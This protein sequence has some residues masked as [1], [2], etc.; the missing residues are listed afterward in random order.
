[1]VVAAAPPRGRLTVAGAALA[2]RREP[3]VQA[4]VLWCVVLFASA[5]Q[6]PSFRAAALKF[7]LRSLA[8]ILAF[9]AARSLARPPPVVR[10][11]VAALIAGALLSAATAL[12][13]VGAPGTA[14]LWSPFREGHFASLGLARASGVFA[15]PTIA[16]M[17]WEAAVPLLVAAPVALRKNVDGD[18]RAAAVAVLA[19]VLPVAAIFAS[20]TRSGLAGTA[21]ACAALLALGW[22]S[23]IGVRRA[24]GGTLAVVVV[25]WSLA[26]LAMPTGSFLGQRL[27][28]WQDENWFRV[29]YLVDTEPRTLHVGEVFTVPVTLHNT[30]AVIWPR[31][32]QQPT[33]LGYHWQRLDGATTL[34]DYEGLRTELPEDVVPGG[35]LEVVAKARGPA[36]EGQY[37]LH[38]DVVQEDV[39]WFSDRGNVMPDQPVTVLPALAGT[40][41]VPASDLEPPKGA[42]PPP[43]RSALWRAAV[44]LW[45]ER[46]VLGIGPDNFRRRYQAVLSPAPTGQPYTDTRLH[47]NSLYFET[48]ADLGL[49]GIVALGCIAL[50]LARLLRSHF[51]EGRLL[52]LA[53]GVAAGAFFVHGALDYFLEF[54]PLLGLFWVLLGLTA[55]SAS[56]PEPA[57]APSAAQPDST[58]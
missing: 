25:W 28:W 6:A 5:A 3:M 8:G 15:Y 47:A 56:G 58:R 20:A 49:A 2:I 33:H 26:A 39:T 1:V 24:A 54:T 31:E 7:S 22:R 13:E 27:Q 19:S 57:P 42:P 32:G 9:F 44:I 11:V 41:P 30:G 40:P 34:A 38:W 48:L 46:P 52:G 16:A 21:I 50:A 51:E 43:A 35:V 55:A 10:Q 23:G 12:L 17:Y 29:E 36:R 4:A 37:L 53:L 18:A 14:W 45:R